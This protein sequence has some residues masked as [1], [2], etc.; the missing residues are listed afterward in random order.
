MCPGSVGQVM[1]YHPYLDKVK[2][3]NLPNENFNILYVKRD[4]DFYFEEIDINDLKDPGKIKGSV[5]WFHDSSIPDPHY[6][7][8]PVDFG[9]FADPTYKEKLKMIKAKFLK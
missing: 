7:K 4:K 2:K 9:W 6:K 5:V 3:F 8:L 1:E